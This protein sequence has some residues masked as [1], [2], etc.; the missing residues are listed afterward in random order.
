[1][2]VKC[3]LGLCSVVYICVLHLFCTDYQYMHW[4]FCTVIHWYCPGLIYRC[5]CVCNDIIIVT[6]T[7]H[8][9][10]ITS[11]CHHIILPPYNTAITPYYLHSISYL[12]VHNERHKAAAGCD[13]FHFRQGQRVLLLFIYKQEQVVHILGQYISEKNPSSCVPSPGHLNSPQSEH[14]KPQ[15]TLR[16]VILETNYRKKCNPV[17]VHNIQT[18]MR[19]WCVYI[20]IHPSPQQLQKQIKHYIIKCLN[21]LIHWILC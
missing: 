9:T 5:L 3:I 21:M 16:T 13:Q 12:S 8:H 20:C 18:Y 11:H 19:R 17:P 6:L 7:S 15:Y 1:M 4:D 14:M 10:D 2:S